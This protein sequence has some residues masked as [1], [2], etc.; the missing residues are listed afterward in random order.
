MKSFSLL[1]L[2]FF[3]TT[4]IKSQIVYNGGWQENFDSMIANNSPNGGNNW[5]SNGNFMILTNDHQ[6]QSYGAN[7]NALSCN[8]NNSNSL[9]SVLTPM[10]TWHGNGSFAAFY[11]RIGNFSGT[12]FIS[13]H[14]LSNGDTCYILIYKCVGTQILPGII[15]EKIHSGNQFVNGS[16]AFAFQVFN[17]PTVL[18][19]DT[20]RIGIKIAKTSSDDYWY[21]F[22]PIEMTYFSIVNEQS[23]KTSNY[24]YPIPASTCFFYETK[25][26]VHEIFI[27]NILGESIPFTLKKDTNKYSVQFENST[28]SGI[29]YITINSDSGIINKKIILEN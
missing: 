2:L 12:S 4:I 20:F 22:D 18:P 11:Y 8:L 5:L 17:L 28:K 6:N 14:N 21:D 15:S 29:Y 27:S 13:Q 24:L 25:D 10:I 1:I 7:G 9:D 16:N 26:L 19:I 23:D 3:F